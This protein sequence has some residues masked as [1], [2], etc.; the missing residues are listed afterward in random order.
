MKASVTAYSVSLVIFWVL[1]KL[2]NYLAVSKIRP[3]GGE[4]CLPR[5]APLRLACGCQSAATPGCLVR[6][7]WVAGG[8]SSVRLEM[9][10]SCA[11]VFHPPAHAILRALKIPL[12]SPLLLSGQETVGACHAG[13]Y[14][15]E[16]NAP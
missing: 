10:F 1:G 7:C 2:I 12:R 16:E 5:M 11:R 4:G 6:M 13:P 15:E 14:N 3:A 8:C 9:Q